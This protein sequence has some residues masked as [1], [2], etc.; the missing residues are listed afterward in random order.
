M[1]LLFTNEWL[2][3][4]IASDP[5]IETEAGRPLAT[6]PIEEIESGKVAVMPTL[7]SAKDRYGLRNE[8]K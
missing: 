3:R 5:D 7:V 1:K 6:P 8:R 4:K 2:R